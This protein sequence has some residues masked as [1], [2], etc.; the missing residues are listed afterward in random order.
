MRPSNEL[1]SRPLLQHLLDLW[2]SP[3][4][5]EGEALYKRLGVLLIKRYLPT[6]GDFSFS[7]TA[8]ASPTFAVVSN[9]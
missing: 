5:F 6:G 8:F 3:K 2:F 7:V 4:R 1:H 9:R